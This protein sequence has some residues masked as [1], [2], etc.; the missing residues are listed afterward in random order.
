MVAFLGVFF[1]GGDSILRF[2]LVT[3]FLGLLGVSIL[4]IFGDSI[5]GFFGDSILGF[6]GQ[7]LLLFFLLG[8]GMYKINVQPLNSRLYG[9]GLSLISLYSNHRKPQAVLLILLLGVLFLFHFLH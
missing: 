7:H 8:G 4:A 1:W 2:F 6:W 9:V 5:L 3:A